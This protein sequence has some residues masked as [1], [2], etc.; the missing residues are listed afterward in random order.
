MKIILRQNF[1]QLGQVG[2]VVDV[3][4]GYARNY[5]IPKKIAYAATK[6]N[7][8][9]L[10]EEKKQQVYREKKDLVRAQKTAQEL[11][12]LSITIPMKVG[13]DDKL[14]GSVTSQMI[15]DVLQEK[16]MAIDKR[17]IEFDE[18]VK[19]LGIYTANVKLHAEVSGKLKV[20]VVKE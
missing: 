13:E 4:D 8:R 19:A 20:W 6:E 2:Q 17:I 3:A 18:A 9:A 7:L 1:E 12:K 5:L 11:E 15:A 14:F 10:E 16:G